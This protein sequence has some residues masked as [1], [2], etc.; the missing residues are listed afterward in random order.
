MW[1]SL[2]H[3]QHHLPSQ[4]VGFESSPRLSCSDS[5]ACSFSACHFVHNHSL[6]CTFLSHVAP[7]LLHVYAS[8]PLPGSAPLMRLYIDQLLKEDLKLAEWMAYHHTVAVAAIVDNFSGL[9]TSGPF[10]LPFHNLPS[11]IWDHLEFGEGS[12][13]WAGTTLKP[14]AIICEILSL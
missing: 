14:L 1:P 11:C 3:C 9:A 12:H 6:L 2:L 10:L 13:P 7:S 4:N 8:Q 5:L